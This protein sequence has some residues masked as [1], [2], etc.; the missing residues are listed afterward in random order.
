MSPPTTLSDAEREIMEAIWAR[1]SAVGA[2]EL[3]AAFAATR[4]W[5][6]QTVATFLTRL[7]EKGML[8]CEKQGAQNRY[9]PTVSASD[10]RAR[11]TQNFLEKE[12]GGSVKSMLS[13]LYD[14][15]GISSDELAALKRWFSEEHPG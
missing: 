9:F 11:R 5:K 2:G 6:I 15:N 10:Y 1:E 7:M 13:A 12:Y 4:G 14:T 3:T 8:L